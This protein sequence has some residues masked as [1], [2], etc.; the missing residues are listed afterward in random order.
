MFATIQTT[1]Q[2]RSNFRLLSPLILLIAVEG[3][4]FFL[5]F[6]NFDVPYTRFSLFV[7]GAIFLT[8]LLPSLARPSTD[9]L[10]AS[11]MAV[12]LA[13]FIV[14]PL[15][16][17][18]IPAENVG[19][20]LRSNFMPYAL[21]LCNGVVILPV[22]LHLASR[23]PAKRRFGP[24][25]LS[26]VYAVT[27]VITGCMLFL[28]AG[29]AARFSMFALEAWMVIMYLLA[30][31]ELLRAARQPVEKSNPITEKRRTQARMLLLVALISS[32]VLFLRPAAYLLGLG[33]LPYNFLLALQVLW[34][35][36][37]GYVVM[38]HDLFGIDLFI[39]RAFGYAVLSLTAIGL[40]L[41]V[42][43]GF[44]LLLTTAL[45]DFRGLATFVALTISAV[46]FEPV[47]KRSQRWI[48]RALYPERL[49]FSR[50]IAALNTR[51]NSVVRREEVMSILTEDLP[52]E[53]QAGW[54]SVSL[55]PAPDVPGEHDSEPVWNHRL[56]VAGAPIGRLWLGP[57]R[58]LRTYDADEQAQLRALA[59]QAALA[60]AYADTFQELD[61]T[62]RQLEQRVQSRTHQVLDQQRTLAAYQERQRI[63]R[64]LHDS[65]SQTLFS[66]NLTARA[67]R[68]LLRSAPDKAEVE[69]QYLEN[70]ARSALQE[71][72]EL[73]AQLRNQPESLCDLVLALQE[74]L[75]GMRPGNGMQLELR[76]GQSVWMEAA[77]ARET[78]QLTREALTNA[79]RHSGSPSAAV[80]LEM[81]NGY[82]LISVED[83][84]AG[85]DPAVLP[86]G[87]Y[88]LRGMYERAV[89]LGGRL[90][91]RSAPGA[92]ACIRL[93][94]PMAG[95]EEQAAPG[96]SGE[97]TS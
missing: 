15:D 77:R 86:E 78:V 52:R 97:E 30:L 54:A 32:L 87:H 50:V 49:T 94:L 38:R 31:W 96:S 27:V 5:L 88:G 22:A 11:I 45:P 68:S 70:D 16:L 17:T 90:E 79:V 53:I 89:E 13:G 55:S 10:L 93:R 25:Q 39:R 35:V 91:V 26:L 1:S 28:P 59:Q 62:N 48:D 66:M 95:N 72:R 18:T 9:S 37:V 83:Q 42:T 40:Y 29:M 64:D 73:L 8:G 44:S 63:A 75:E 7:G 36:G 85:F 69:L 41:L 84:G 65:V 3:L 6:K 34:P 20:F 60:L 74:L 43:L 82:V 51:L 19:E 92:G 81:Q 2:P 23:F 24:L 80:T 47:R 57:R 67:L 76:A 46:V 21:R 33:V 4:V 14:I 61:E 58:T 71:M 12:A 56:V